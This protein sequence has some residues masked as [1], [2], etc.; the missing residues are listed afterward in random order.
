V[1]KPG[2]V[3]I[4]IA[5]LQGCASLTGLDAGS[6]FSCEAPDGVYCSSVSGVYANAVKENL[7][8]QQVNRQGHDKESATSTQPANHF[9]AT[10]YNRETLQLPVEPGKLWREA[11]RLRLWIAPWEDVQGDLHDQSYLY[12]VMND[13]GWDMEHNLDFTA[14]TPIKPERQ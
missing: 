4:A 6:E 3:I 7:P 5:L 8:S 10:R 2:V 14:K 13:G 9:Y 12:V 1:I 11:Q